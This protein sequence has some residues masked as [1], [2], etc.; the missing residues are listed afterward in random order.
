MNQSVNI[1]PALVALVLPLRVG[2]QI[3]S[4]GDFEPPTWPGTVPGYT[5]QGTATI[6][7]DVPIHGTQSLRFPATGDGLLLTIP[8]TPSQEYEV[9]FYL[10]TQILTLGGLA[11]VEAD[12]ISGGNLIST[13]GTIA[14]FNLPNQPASP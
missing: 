8:T 2:A 12:L 11:C 13:G 14:A 4:G 7:S 3:L 10:R 5:L 6:I 1:T 9:D